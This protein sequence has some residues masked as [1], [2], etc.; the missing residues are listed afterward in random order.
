MEG[1]CHELPKPMLDVQG[2]PIL[3][4]TIDHLIKNGIGQI[5]INTH[6]QYQVIEDF[7]KGTYS[8]EV[9][10]LEREVALSGTAGALRCFKNF[11]SD[12]E[13]FIVIAGDILTDYPYQ[14]LIDFHRN[15]K[16][17]ASF[18]FHE[19]KKSNSLLEIDHHQKVT[20]FFER[21]NEAIFDQKS[22]H[23]INSSIYCF[24][25]DVLDQIPP[26]GVSDIPRDLFPLFLEEGSLFATPLCAQ[27]WAIDTPERLEQA[28]KEFK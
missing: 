6:H 7:I 2:K 25:R 18:V 3:G 8:Q 4:H 11:L 24:N 12:Q 14:E 1:L 9:I 27:R 10:H 21:P 23:K 15:K 28:R 22:S 16:A 26:E 17:R 20:H 19:R 13:Q 5:G